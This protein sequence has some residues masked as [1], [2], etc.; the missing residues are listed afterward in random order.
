MCLND[1]QEKELKRIYEEPMLMKLG[2]SKKFPRAALCSR[3]S[4]LGIG[5]MEPS[6]I[7]DVLKLKLFIGSMRKRG[8]SANYTQCQLEHQV[9]EAGRNIRLGENPKLRHLNKTWVDEINDLLWKRDIA[10]KGEENKRIIT[11]DNKTLMQCAI[12]YAQQKNKDL[13]TLK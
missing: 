7:V 1:E 2:L 4:T 6:T 9:V 10:L 11:S 3:K 13:E 8:N 5:L 12:D